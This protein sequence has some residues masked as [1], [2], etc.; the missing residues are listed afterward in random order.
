HIISHRPSEDEPGL[1]QEGHVQRAGLWAV[2]GYF[3][4]GVGLIVQPLKAHAQQPAC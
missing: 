2:I 1:G 3:N 4:V